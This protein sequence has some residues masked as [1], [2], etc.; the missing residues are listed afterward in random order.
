[1][2]ARAGAASTP[3]RSRGC[4]HPG[5]SRDRLRAPPGRRPRG[6]DPRSRGSER[7]RVRFH[8]GRARS[9]HRRPTATPMPIRKRR[10]RPMPQQRFGSW[11]AT[12]GLTQG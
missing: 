7:G 9:N 2:R 6:A 5:S 1:M 12:A 11:N 10:L 4:A 3:P 8:D